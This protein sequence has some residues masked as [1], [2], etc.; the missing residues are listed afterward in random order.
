[1]IF[2]VT[3]VKFLSHI[4]VIAEWESFNLESITS[5]LF[6]ISFKALEILT[7]KIWIILS[8]SWVIL[9]FISS[10]ESTIFETSSLTFVSKFKIFKLSPIVFTLL[11]T[12]V[13]DSLSCSEPFDI[14]SKMD[15][16]EFLN[17]SSSV[18]EEISFM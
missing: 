10:L 5:A 11:E 2:S 3:S 6:D 12:A 15:S 7:S 18:L 13:K 1:M 16:K 14:S 4:S 17:S 9:P 8:D